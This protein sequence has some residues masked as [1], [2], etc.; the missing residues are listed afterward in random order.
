M[1]TC[2][3]DF[4]ISKIGSSLLWSSFFWFFLVL[5]ADRTIVEVAEF[6]VVGLLLEDVDLKGESDEVLILTISYGNLLDQE[7]AL[8]EWTLDFEADLSYFDLY[9][10]LTIV[11]VSFI[12]GLNIPSSSF[13]STYC[14]WRMTHSFSFWR[15]SAST[16]ILSIN[17]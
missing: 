3:G 8:W 12:A 4:S 15:H 11:L 17:P 16:C 9:Q 6:V 1:K 5:F 7:S 2:K 10:D 13:S 14:L